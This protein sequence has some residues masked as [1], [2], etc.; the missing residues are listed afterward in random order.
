MDLINWRV[1]LFGVM[2]GIAF[3]LMQ[4]GVAQILLAQNQDCVLAAE[5]MRLVDQSRLTC[6]PEFSVAVLESFATG[7]LPVLNPGSS[8]LLSVLSM[9]I[10]LG[11]LGGFFS[12]F[13][14]RWAVGF[15]IA[16][17]VLLIF[18]LATMRYLSN[19]VQV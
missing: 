6:M 12:Q 18:L 16:V 15:F 9:T 7:F 8:F 13:S 5:R 10:A 19:Y 1:I 3:A 11:V 4:A 14:D 2:L 17:D